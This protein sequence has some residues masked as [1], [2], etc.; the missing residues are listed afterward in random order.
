[1]TIYPAIKLLLISP[2]RLPIPAYE[3]GAVENLLEI[4]LEFNEAHQ[5]FEILCA[6]ASP[7]C[8]E[9]LAAGF[10]KTSFLYIKT[11]SLRFLVKK[12]LF[13]VVRFFGFGLI[14]DVYFQEVLRNLGKKIHDFDLVV[15][16]NTPE[17]IL[18]LRKVYKG[19]VILHL[20]NNYLYQ[21]THLNEEIIRSFDEI[22]GVSDFIL[23][24][25]QNRID[26]QRMHL[27]YNGIKVGKFNP[28]NP[29][30]D[31]RYS[32]AS[33]NIRP[34]EFVILY[35]GRVAES[36][37]IMLLIDAFKKLAKIYPA[38]LIIAGAPAFK[39]SS[40]DDCMVGARALAADLADRVIFLGYVDY[41]AMPSVY[42]IADIGVVPSLQPEGFGLTALE[43]L[44]AGN[45]VATTGLGGLSEVIDCATGYLLPIAS[46]AFIDKFVAIIGHLYENPELQKSM[47]RL[48]IARAERFSDSIYSQRFKSLLQES[49]A[50]AVAKKRHI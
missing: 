22:Y 26:S 50:R 42:R 10:K 23:S 2:G 16:E 14:E 21:K 19:Y 11:R 43:H 41:D 47:S 32:R 39:N 34:D 4:F 1:M 46:D 18:P 38:R 3:G 12:A 49:F 35:A 40:D 25:L 36:K 29:L 20:H 31:C 5:H 13:K 33:L 17:Y 45:P 27:L 7:L 9:G 30:E 6:S 24:Q 37:G 8:Q 28:K 48:A 44:A 15:I